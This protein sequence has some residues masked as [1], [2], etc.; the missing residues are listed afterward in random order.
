MIV[1]LL[2]IGI[3]AFTMACSS[4]TEENGGEEQIE[5][6][7]E[8]LAQYNGK[9]G[10]PAYVA[11]DGEIYDVSDAGPWSGGEHN[12][13]EAGNDLSEEIEEIS[14]HGK[15]VLSNVPKIG[16]LVEE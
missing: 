4:G 5:L 13:F 12:G 1:F 10:N 6:T 3:M 15:S 2:I 11:V 9:D 8:E 7:M 14:P 16:V